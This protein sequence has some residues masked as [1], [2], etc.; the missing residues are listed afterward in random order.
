MFELITQLVVRAQNTVAAAR[1][2]EGQTLVEYALILALVSIGTIAT[3]LL[4]TGKLNTV[5]NQVANAI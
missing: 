4:V 1:E 2:E 3:L 5:F